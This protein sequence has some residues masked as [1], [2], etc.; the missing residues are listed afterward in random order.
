MPETHRDTPLEDR[1]TEHGARTSAMCGR[2]LWASA[3][4]IAEPPR[5]VFPV[6]RSPGG[7]WAGRF[8]VCTARSI[9]RDGGRAPFG[10]HHRPCRSL[11]ACVL[12]TDTKMG[13]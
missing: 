9:R 6:A 4:P 2:V 7:T 1:A 12:C 8:S 3:V 11:A 13:L 10:H 5:S